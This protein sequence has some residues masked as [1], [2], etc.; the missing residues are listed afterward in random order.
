[1]E[2]ENS[3][4]DMRTGTK[5]VTL[6]DR[7]PWPDSLADALGRGE[8]TAVLS[9]AGQG[10][11]CLNELV[12]LQEADVGVRDL[13][14]AA[15][16]RLRGIVEAPTLA[17][18]GHYRHGLDPERWI[19]APETRPPAE[20]LT[21]SPISQPLVLLNQIAR[22]EAVCAEGLAPALAAG[23]V[24]AL[25]GH[26]QGL[27]AAVLVAASPDGRI[28][29]DHLLD[30]LT[31]M[32]WQGFWM[33]EAA[34]CT[35][36][37]GEAT[38]MAAVSGLSAESLG[39]ILEAWS[40]DQSTGRSVR[41]VVNNS[42]TRHVLSG[43]A[44][45]VEA[46]RQ[47][48]LARREE[49]SE[50]G[51]RARGQRAI[52]SFTW[53]YLAV[54]APFHTPHMRPA[55]QRMAQTR[56]EL[57]FSFAPDGLHLPVLCPSGRG[58]LNDLPD[59]DAAV[60]EAQFLLPVRWPQTIRALCDAVAL[61]VILD[62]GPG[63]GVARL[64]AGATRGLGVQVAALTTP[65]GRERLFTAGAS[66]PRRRYADFAP[67]LGILPDGRAVLANRYTRATGRS[68]VILP[69][70][71]PTTVDAGICAAA[72][73]AGFTVE[74]A[75][76]GQVTAEILDLRL[77]ELSGLLVP[78]AEVVFNA[79]Y[80]DRYLWDLHLGRH[81]KV[82]AARRAG[83]PICGV[84]ISA[85]IPEPDQAVALL[86]ELAA[87][88]MEQNAFKPGT[89]AQVEQ[90]LKIARRARHHTV[91]MHLEGGR[92]GGHHSWE[93]LDELLLACY[94]NVRAEPNV[95]LCVGGGVADE[96]RAAE[97]LTGRWAA[98][99]G[100][101]P[102]PV[103]AVLLGT[104][105]MACR[106]APAAPQV[107]GAVAAAAGGEGW[108]PRG[109][110]SGGVTSG[111]SGLGAD[112]H[113]LDNAAARCAR[114]LDA[115]AGD[116]AA[117][118][119]RREEIITALAQTAKP[120]FGDIE[121]MTWAT[122]LERAVALM[123]IGRG[124]RY[125]DGPWPDRSYRM[126]VFDLLRRAEARLVAVDQ[127]RFSPV[128]A[129]P[130]MLD[131]PGEA[132]ACFIAAY[133]ATGTLRPTPSDAAHFV[134]QICARPGKPVNFVPVIDADVRRWYASD[135]LWQAQDPRYSAEQVLVIPGPAAVRG[136]QHA[137][138]PIAV[139]LSRFEAAVV[140]DLR[141][142]GVA[143]T[144]IGRRR[145]PH[146]IAATPPATSEGSA[147]TLTADARTRS[148]DWV[149]WIG[150]HVDGAIA[151]LLGSRRVF[152]GTRSVENPLRRLC[153][154]EAGARM[155]VEAERVTLH[156]VGADALQICGDSRGITALLSL[157]GGG[158]LP[159]GFSP[160][161]PDGEFAMAPRGPA[162]RKLY[163][164]ALFG[165]SLEPVPLFEAAHSEVA[166][167]SQRVRAWAA[168]TG[169]TPDEIPLD[170]VFSVAWE[171]IMRLLSCD[172]L[173]EGLA[174]L[175]HLEHA[176]AWLP[177][178]PRRW[179][180]RLQV[181]ARLTRVIDDA[182]GRTID[183]AVD[184]SDR[185][186]PAARLRERFLIRGS[187]AHT[188]HSLRRRDQHALE[189]DLSDPS[190][191]GFL[192]ELDWIDLP[193]GE[194]SGSARMEVTLSTEI[195]RRGEPIYAARGVIR[196]GEEILASVELHHVGALERHPM[197]A[198]SAL[199]DVPEATSQ[200]R[201]SRTLAIETDHAPAS[202]A[203]FAAVGGDH[204]P[205]HRSPLVARLAGLERPIVHGMWTS[206]R[207]Q[208]FA[209]SGV[210]GDITRW[211]VA[212]SAPLLP[213][214]P[215]RLRATRTGVRDGAR[216]VELT[217]AA[218]RDGAEVPVAR[219][220]TEIRPP[221]TAYVFPGQGIQRPGMGMAGYT[222]SAAARRIWDRAD[223]HTRAALGFSILRVV[224]ENPR[225][226][227]VNGETHRHPRGVLH[228]TRFTQVAMAVL[229][230]AQVEELREAGVLDARAIACGHSVGE[231][232]ALSAIAGILPLEAVVE[233]V[234][235]RGAAMSRLVPRDAGGASAYRMVAVRPSAVG[236]NQGSLERLVGE[237]AR[238]TGR[239]LQ[240]VNHNVRDEQYA[241]TGH[242]AAVAA[243]IADIA[244]RDNPT[245]RRAVVVVPGVDVPFHS[246]ALTGGVAE[247]RAVLE[248]HLPPRLPAERLVDR[249]IPNL[250]ASPF[251][252]ERSFIQRIADATNSPT[253][254][255]ILLDINRYRVDPDRLA[256]TLLVELLAWQFASPVRWIET[257]ERLLAPRD[258]GGMGVERVIEIGSGQQ[259]TLRN[260]A[261]RTL[262]GLPDAPRVAVLNVE[263]DDAMVFER[264]ADLTPVV[265]A[266]TRP[267]A[268]EVPAAEPVIAASPRHDVPDGPA[269][270]PM[271][272]ADALRV[273]LAAQAR[274]RPDQISG[275]ESID[276]L[277]EGVSSRR[278]Q[279]LIDIGAEFGISAPGGASELPLDALA[280]EIAQRAPG[281]RAPGPYLAGMRDAG[282]RDVFGA[283]GWSLSAAEDALRQT[284]GLGPGLTAWALIRM[285]LAVRSGDSA[286]GGVLG[287]S[288]PSDLPGAQAALD[289]VVAGLSERIGAPIPDQRRA[290]AGPTVDSAA[291]DALRDEL[292]GADG[293]LT[294][295]VQD[296]A[297]ALVPS[298]PA[299]LQQTTLLGA[300]RLATL[301]AELGADF[302]ERIAP[303]FDARRH[304]ALLDAWAGARRDLAAL[305]WDAANHRIAPARQRALA[306]RLSRHA[307][308]PVLRAM[309]HWFAPRVPAPTGEL[310]SRIAE[311]E[312]IPEPALPS[313]SAAAALVD[314]HRLD[315]ALRA[316][317]SVVVSAPL[318]LRGRTALVTGAS[319]GGIAEEIVRHLLRGG[320]RVIV[321]TSRP[322][323]ERLAHYRERYRRW[324]APGAELHVVPFN[325]A[326][327]QDVDALV[328]WLLG[329]QTETDGG[330]TRLLKPAMVP[331]LLI[332]FAAATELVSLDRV[333]GAAEA[334]LRA[335]LLGTERLI[336]GVASR[337]CR[338]GVPRER[339][340]VLVPLSPN[341]GD[342]GSDGLYG[343]AKAALEV[344]ARKWRSEHDAWGRAVTLC[345]A[346]IGWVRGTA[347]MAANDALADGLEAQT[348]ARTFSAAEM[349]LLLAALCAEPARERARQRPL[350]V[351]LTAGLA[352]VSTLQEI[353][354]AVRDEREAAAF[355]QR[356][357]AALRRDWRALLGLRDP[358]AADALPAPASP[359][360]P[361]GSWPLGT[362]TLRD[363][364]VIVGIGEIGPWGS[365][366]TRWSAE[367]DAELSPAAVL[368]LA[369]MTGLVRW[370]K[371]AGWV[372]AVTR[373]PV[374]ES[375]IAERYRAAVRERAGL[376]FIAPEQ[377]GYDPEAL[378]ILQTVY[379]ERDFSFGVASEEEARSFFA[380]DPTHT[381]ITCD[382]DGAWRVTRTAG[383]RIRVSRQ[384]RLARS[385]AGALPEGFAF[386]RYGI[387]PALISRV[388]RTTLLNLAAT[389]DAFLSAG[390]SPEELMAGV[391]PA[392]VGNTQGT[393]IGGISSLRR[394]VLDHLLGEERQGDILQ[395]SLSN[396]IAAYVVQSF[397]GS[398][399]PMSHPVGACATA[400]VSV[401]DACDKIRADKADVVVAGGFDDLGVEGAVGFADMHAT[402]DTDAMSA[403]GL[404][405]DQISRGNDRRRR[406]FVPAQG[407][408]TLLLARGD[409]ALQM[410][411]P[412]LGVVAWAGSFGDGIHASIPA[413]GRGLLSAASGG[414]ASPLGRA[415]RRHGLSADDVAVVSKHDTSTAAND[416]GENDL[417]QRIQIALGRTPGNP[418]AVISQ[419]S[420]TG[421]SKGGAAAWQIA[422]LCQALAD[423][424]IPGNRN[425]ECLDDSARPHDHLL[426]SDQSLRPGPA[427]PLRAGLVTSLGFGH[428]SG[429]ALVLHPDAFHALIPEEDRA[430]YRARAQVRRATG[431]RRWEAVRMGRAAAFEARTKRR[432]SAP[433]GSP[434]QA[435]EEAAML[436]DPSARLD[437]ATG[438]LRGAR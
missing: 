281:W 247:F 317:V 76:G 205:I 129:D 308:D 272:I 389:A 413:P 402:A 322:T 332:P 105:A 246:T 204:N 229:A 350:H 319:P 219:V 316:L 384:V 127:G 48:L 179:G 124:G 173:V 313:P 411:L 425:L 309:A 203:A 34:R 261:R 35:G 303:R 424:V 91:F 12:A 348:G 288:T 88:G 277:F 71:T 312:R 198:F 381:R 65:G 67:T 11:P 296:A 176:A 273:L 362:A 98:A 180:P 89:A 59:L 107:T 51:G 181:R 371:S 419:K 302:A 156:T 223:A 61:D 188:S 133:P 118:D 237:I 258:R 310:L 130:G 406:G 217:C 26:S 109:A 62:L 141:T 148:A 276:D 234:Y 380:S 132:L 31:Y 434:A 93:S 311:G 398:Y 228:R 3:P 403:M 378:P 137:D 140:D 334:G 8:A 353:I 416:P 245:G 63:D 201:P 112:I 235:Q 345:M 161:G 318:D 117:V 178:R 19:T 289:A 342:M 29:R 168:L 52:P 390:L 320:A 193:D 347:L 225:G 97:L 13:I 294:R 10:A 172:A 215:L 145:A 209:R 240:V 323:R 391:H 286:R 275:A 39:E 16:E 186:V 96:A 33:Q 263:C 123:A 147:V 213:G 233:I 191:V 166:V 149:D 78:G 385:V 388:D 400:A 321:T 131:Q 28:D 395:E 306:A 265:P 106:E 343:E 431:Q 260:M 438:V 292:I 359:V 56:R 21:S 269:D 46:F 54:S 287:D 120:Y 243:L 136:I 386:E 373:E 195:P 305:A 15:S 216:R 5:Q 66:T 241:I 73:N 236:L 327:A 95:V 414:M 349:G 248:H 111:R 177:G 417:H 70:M 30:A 324:A 436:L 23:S 197:D 121:E 42:R 239:F 155:V 184:L 297:A 212:F 356:R 253:C 255:A 326:S 364:V 433:D 2:T 81:G 47:H 171:P 101:P 92:A 267:T 426:F 392:R 36:T 113:Y 376:R 279:A 329:T 300:E 430:D 242:E 160:T 90:V 368:E 298:T 32:A 194:F 162:L 278:N 115:V 346:R 37:A 284:W 45:A 122:A 325:Q 79:L 420:L 374:V 227:I 338:D 116:A 361:S 104:V 264:G 280:A 199:L 224:R 154:A 175:V 352:V 152:V 290:A 369:W 6:G 314:D 257:Q 7:S 206:A 100:E 24:C 139:L 40:A 151:R 367:I 218:L 164:R 354:R 18:S 407:G 69:G 94:H 9:F 271:P 259:P 339:L 43:P 301:D 170:F 405:P 437:L 333:G 315:P 404:A 251:R 266:S 114:L 110:A 365:A 86:D 360:V 335:M 103:D 146:A 328:D 150:A 382:A 230:Q 64:T 182:A 163:H 331:D 27:V 341:H 142:A 49:A 50:R 256:R 41:V 87:L 410:G 435:D 397:V 340:H 262:A 153:R 207:L 226:L 58:P 291:L 394:L 22:Y 211:R 144:P 44:E 196:Q 427:A 423:G 282:L 159:L 268:P 372:D 421:H 55:L 190:V 60:M 254:A 80:L 128:I 192:H 138:E 77:E 383:A 337:L 304:V 99:H 231:Y 158:S 249:Y 165:R 72:A 157:A 134:H 299:L 187:Y 83:A 75:G 375:E 220:E 285:A 84:T 210:G 85:G 214:E 336:T 169:A 429:V 102:M 57:G 357:C 250:V 53:E 422:G 222:R 232:N 119:S 108:V 25:T 143:P 274:V 412:V 432:L 200:P 17:W 68:P 379:L 244:G 393:G 174:D 418:L 14:A 74:L 399:G 408:G 82:Q 370:E 208:G 125:E 202:M 415:L 330:T 189:L 428:V 252:L 20:Y 377:V 4:A 409:V 283:A 355:Q 1:M 351:D 135:S 344:L 363:T 307:G 38:P 238:R 126:R 221:R 401:A 358:E 387:P 270:R 167:D 366:R 396:V 295:V 183:V 293:V 185:G